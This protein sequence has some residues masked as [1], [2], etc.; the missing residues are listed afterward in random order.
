MLELVGP[1]YDKFPGVENIE[2]LLNLSLVA[3]NIGSMKMAFPQLYKTMLQGAKAELGDNKEDI[4]ILEK[5]IK[6]RVKKFAEYDEFIHDFEINRTDDGQFFVVATAKPLAAF[7]EDM[8]LDD[9][10]EDEESED[11][12]DDFNFE[13]GF[14]NRIAITITPKQAFVDW[15]QKIEGNTLFPHKIEDDNIY[16]LEEKDTNE[17]I[18]SYLRKNFDK[19]FVEELRLWYEDEKSWPANRNYKM[20]R[21]WFSVAYTAAVYDL[22]DFPVDKE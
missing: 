22:E 11:E 15:L 6:E 13:A 20:F 19:I 4:Q 17:E 18:E 9:E 12:D 2:N 3:W 14:I 21:E 8:M 7:L 16:L 1:Y 10:D 5:L